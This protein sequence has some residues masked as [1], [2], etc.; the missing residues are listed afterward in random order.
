[1]STNGR[2]TI[3]E[4]DDICLFPNIH[5]HNAN[6]PCWCCCMCLAYTP[7]LIILFLIIFVFG[8]FSAF[9][10]VV[11][12]KQHCTAG[13]LIFVIISLLLGCFFTTL[14]L[15]AFINVICTCAGYV[16]NTIWQYPPTYIGEMEDI[17]QINFNREEVGINPHTVK[18]L[19][20]SKTLRFCS[21]CHLFQPDFAH[22]CDVCKRCT[23]RFDHHCP[24]INNCVGRDNYKMFILFLFYSSITGIIEGTLMILGLFVIFKNDWNFLWLTVPVIAIIMA[25]G[26]L[27]FA[28]THLCWLCDGDSTMSSH[29]ASLQGKTSQ[30]LSEAEREIKKI[31]HWNAVLGYDRRWWR[32]ILPFRPTPALRAEC[33]SS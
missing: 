8:A 1:M 25:L 21:D 28:I 13:K 22:H 11:C 26:V 18:Q 31:D 30:S 3:D 27:G 10:I 5:A 32:V 4:D 29:I 33:V 19:S 16:P 14:T 6:A 20:R 2:S 15:L 24:A 7:A 12:I 23:Y 17:K 9:F